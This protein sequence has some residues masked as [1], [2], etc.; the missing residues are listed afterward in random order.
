VISCPGRGAT[1]LDLHAGA[2]QRLSLILPEQLDHHV[3]PTLGLNQLA[4]PGIVPH[5]VL[6]VQALTGE[7][8]LVGVVEA[9]LAA[10]GSAR[11]VPAPRATCSDA[12]PHR[13]Y[14]Q[15]ETPK[16]TCKHAANRNA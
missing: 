9:Q 13:S 8:G 7:A 4:T 5:P 6:L 16:R 14:L 15:L 1:H 3:R 10:G 2:Q 11:S 12:K